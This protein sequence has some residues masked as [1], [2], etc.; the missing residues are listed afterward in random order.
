MPGP[1]YVAGSFNR[2]LLDD[3]N[4]MTWSPED[5]WYYID[6][7]LKQGLYEYKYYPDFTSTGLRRLS[8][9]ANRYTGLVYLR[10]PRLNTDRLVAISSLGSR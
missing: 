10:D 4:I 7:L 8:N 5:K 9:T 3:K 2:W 6:V 1:V